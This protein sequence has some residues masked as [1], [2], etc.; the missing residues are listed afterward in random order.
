M[1]SY[2]YWYSGTRWYLDTW[3]TSTEEYTIRYL[4]ITETVLVFLW[5]GTP[6]PSSWAAVACVDMWRMKDV[7]LL[8]GCLW[9]SESVV[10]WACTRESVT[11]LVTLLGLDGS[12]SWSA[13]KLSNK[14]KG[15]I[16]SPTLLHPTR[17]AAPGS[18]R[19]GREEFNGRYNSRFRRVSFLIGIC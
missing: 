3:T 5:T 10:Y 19:N 2:L 8:V 1:S 17:C 7:V 16:L 6:L 15:K 14:V 12:D 11:R 18:L 4:Y 13:L 9:W